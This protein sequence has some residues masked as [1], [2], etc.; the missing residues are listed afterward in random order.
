MSHVFGKQRHVDLCE[1]EASQVC[2][3]SSRLANKGTASQ[4]NYKVN[5]L[6]FFYFFN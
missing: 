5:I 2:I 4:E 3:A 1:F 6:M